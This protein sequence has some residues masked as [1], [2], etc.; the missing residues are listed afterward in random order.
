LV[1]AVAAKG[2]RTPSP[3]QRQCIPAVLEGRDV[4][5]AAQTGTGKTAGFTLPLLERLRHGPP[6]RAGVLM[7]AAQR[8]A[9]PHLMGRLFKAMAVCHPALPPLPG[10]AA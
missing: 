5:A 7:Q 8:L 10:F 6:A 3:I 4:M 9:E 2:Y 1:K